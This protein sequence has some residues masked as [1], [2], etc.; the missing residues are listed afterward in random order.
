MI[1]GMVCPVFSQQILISVSVKQPKKLVINAGPD[2][3]V[4]NSENI[5]I[6]EDIT[7]TGGTP[8]YL[9]SWSDA[10]G[11]NFDSQV[12]M[13][14]AF[15]TYYLNVYDANNCSAV[16][17]LKVINSVNVDRLK[18]DNLLTL[19]PNPASGTVFVPLQDFNRE[20][21]LDILSTSGIV[22]YRQHIEMSEPK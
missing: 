9:Y 15:G 18:E 20:L 5:T 22:L 12:P 6:G 13:V 21:H 2:I 10:Y 7:V 1:L 11:N 14:S 19:F 8:G 4:E 17:S 16:D 3:L